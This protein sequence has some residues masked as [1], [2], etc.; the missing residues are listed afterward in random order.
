MQNVNVPF[1]MLR[2]DQCSFHKKRAGTAC[3]ELVFLHHV[4]YAGHSVSGRETSI[5]YF[6]CLD[7]TGTD[8]LKSAPGD[9]TPR[10][11]NRL[12][13]GRVE[14]LPARQQRGYG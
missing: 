1:F 13:S 2:W 8:S 10:D 6:S 9:P 12:G 5:H 14:Q 4:A 11:G 3:T 7:G